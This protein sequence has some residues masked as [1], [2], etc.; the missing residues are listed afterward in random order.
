MKN[1]Q[2]VSFGGSEIILASQLQAGLQNLGFDVAVEQQVGPSARADI[3]AQGR[4]R[5]KL[6]IQIKSGGAGDYLSVGAIAGARGTAD[7][8]AA[9]GVNAVPVVYTNMQVSPASS[10]AADAIAVPVIHASDDTVQV[11]T[12]LEAVLRACGVAIP[13]EPESA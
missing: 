7:Y 13:N 9:S 8:L 10:R 1:E 12:Q 5:D 3:V 11:V 2:E 6:V 4:G